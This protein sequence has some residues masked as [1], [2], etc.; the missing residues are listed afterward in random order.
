MILDETANDDPTDYVHNSSHNSSF[1]VHSKQFEN[2]LSI[3]A[4]N[5]HCGFIQNMEFN[6]GGYQY[7]SNN[8]N[9]SLLQQ[10]NSDHSN[11]LL[12]MLQNDPFISTDCRFIT[13]SQ[14][15]YFHPYQQYMCR[16]ANNNFHNVNNYA[17]YD[18]SKLKPIPLDSSQISNQT[19]IKLE[20]LHDPISTISR[21]EKSK[22]GKSNQLPPDKSFTCSN[23]P[24]RF[25]RKDELR[26]HEKI[27]TGIK[28][29]CCPY[30]D[31]TFIRS[32]H[33]RTHIRTHTGEKPYSCEICCKCFARSDERTRHTRIHSKDPV[34][35][36]KKPNANNNTS[37]N[38]YT[39]S[40]II[41]LD[42]LKSN[43]PLVQ[44]KE[45]FVESY[46]QIHPEIFIR[47]SLKDP[48]RYNPAF[49]N[50]SLIRNKDATTKS[51][52]FIKIEPHINDAISDM[53]A[54][55]AKYY[56]FSDK[57]SSPSTEISID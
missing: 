1:E 11:D 6:G 9:Y 45:P 30:C 46:Y 10:L 31:K 40:A 7:S 56:H 33:R 19:N 14:S 20:P 50:N 5:D 47:E 55:I 54:N 44:N 48:S 37:N 39:K 42:S 2:L 49:D 23:C 57:S 29:L 12:Q 38:D 34:R 53:T 3:P 25:T 41:D 13:D 52:A 16:I 43:L 51:K 4:Y 35:K 17:I 26:R 24:S 28:T 32:D 27:H 8:G 36:R 21:E 22:S 15:Q 18:N